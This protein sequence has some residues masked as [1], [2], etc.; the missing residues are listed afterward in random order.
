DAVPINP[1][2]SNINVTLIRII[3]IALCNFMNPPFCNYYSIR[4]I[5]T[6]PTARKSAR[7]KTGEVKSPLLE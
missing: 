4:K 5:G 1:A 3:L 6:G 7:S 2:S